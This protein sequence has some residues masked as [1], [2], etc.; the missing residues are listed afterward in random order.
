M[1]FETNRH[2]TT[3]EIG[4]RLDVSKS[5]IHEHLMEL[6]FVERLDVWV[7]HKLSER[8]LMD[9]V[10]VC[11][12]LLKRNE[13]EPFPKRMVTGDEKW[14][15]YNDVERKRSWSYPATA[16]LT[17]L[18]FHN[19]NERVIAARPFQTSAVSDGLQKL[20]LACDKPETTA[21]VS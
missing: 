7:P 1:V 13:N 9:P 14:I 8:N 21:L 17:M 20:A 11:D 5:T 6:G 10:S 12:S 19:D 15:V 3:R 16:T 2:I 18:R 4:E